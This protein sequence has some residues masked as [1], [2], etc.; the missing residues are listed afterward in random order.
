MGGLFDR[1][2]PENTYLI[3]DA[4]DR[5]LAGALYTLVWYRDE[6]EPEVDSI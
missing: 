1:F 2:Q 3:L 4:P 6:Y 5:M